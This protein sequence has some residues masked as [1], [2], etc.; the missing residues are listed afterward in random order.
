MNPVSTPSGPAQRFTPPEWRVA[1]LVS[2]VILGK[3]PELEAVLS[4]GAHSD[5]VGRLGAPERAERREGRGKGEH[6]RSNH[7]PRGV[8]A[9]LRSS[10]CY[11][12]REIS[13]FPCEFAREGG[14]CA[15]VSPVAFIRS[16]PCD[17]RPS[18]KGFHMLPSLRRKNQKLSDEEAA[19]IAGVRVGTIRSRVARAR[20]DLIAG[21]G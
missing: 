21:T 12:A 2:V 10:W 16:F 18:S 6:E 1:C 5:G 3:L 11:D 7:Y 4:V 9:A 14:G 13:S 19:K 8:F 17:D 15:S 20:K